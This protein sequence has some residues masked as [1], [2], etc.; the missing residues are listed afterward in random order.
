MGKR[1]NKRIALIL[2]VLYNMESK[3]KEVIHTSQNKNG[4]GKYQPEKVWNQLNQDDPDSWW[5]EQPEVPGQDRIINMETLKEELFPED[6][7][8]DQGDSEN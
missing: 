1:H 6:D 3:L 5:E 2:K 4:H 7:I 8:N